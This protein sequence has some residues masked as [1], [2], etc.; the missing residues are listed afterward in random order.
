[1]EKCN[2]VIMKT[3]KN[4]GLALAIA[5]TLVMTAASCSSENDLVE[6]PNVEQPT[7]TQNSKVHVTVG[8]G[9]SDV[10]T[11]SV[12]DKSETDANGKPIRKLK[13]TAGDKLYVYAKY[14]SV[15]VRNEGY[16]PKFITGWLDILPASITDGTSASFTGDLTIYEWNKSENKYVETTHKFTNADPLVDCAEYCEQKGYQNEDPPEGVFAQLVHAGS[17]ANFYV[18]DDPEYMVFCSN[19]RYNYTNQDYLA[20]D[21]DSYMT[22]RLEV[23]ANTYDKD[24]HRFALSSPDNTAIFNCVI[25]GLPANTD[26]HVEIVVGEGAIDRGKVKTDGAGNAQFVAA[27]KEIDLGAERTYSIELT[28]INNSFDTYTISLGS[29]TLEKKIYNVS[30]HWNGTAF[31]KTIDLSTISHDMLVGSGMTLTGELS[32][33]YKI[34][35]AAGATVTLSGATIP[36]RDAT[37]KTTQW[38][39][40]TCLGDATIV[41]ADGTENYVKGYYCDFPGIQAG[42]AGTTLTIR[43]GSAGTGKLTAHTGM[44]NVGYAAGIGGGQDMAVGNIR[45]EGGDITATA[46]RGAA[47]IGSGH[48]YC[49][50]A[51]CGDITITGGTV[52]ATG[53]YDGAGIGSGGGFGGSGGSGGSGGKSGIIQKINYS[54][55]GNIS[56][57][58]GIIN[59]TGGTDSPCDIG[60]GGGNNA[61]CG[62]VS[63]AP[64]TINNLFACTFVV[65]Y[66]ASYT[67]SNNTVTAVP[68]YNVNSTLKVT[69]NGKNYTTTS[70][71]R[72]GETVTIDLSAVNGATVTV[73]TPNGTPY[74]SD[75]YTSTTPQPT[76]TFSCTIEN[77]TITGETNLGT[78]NLI[79][80][81]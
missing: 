47:G 29:R 12:V 22:S 73:S 40:I 53:G 38:A 70:T 3:F 27:Y 42:P 58:G 2:N 59:A 36:G 81:Q 79:R 50:T 57:S 66:Y 48:A 46:G 75:Q 74:D 18:E 23:M 28:N 30:R 32:G 68:V 71:Y 63:V 17:E 60:K 54:S 5:A 31:S 33:N 11:R 7:V 80:Q 35:I 64:G 26:Y 77:V 4:C 67:E 45:I 19:F 61:S 39:G 16:Y 34:S 10:M 44:S 24:N 1:M 76:A 20:P 37:D 25:S 15:Y 43:G 8:A 72:D 55:C 51:S 65:K 69:V 9:I 21:I 49:S 78:V 14:G 52:K 41:L 56:I 62:T 6:T 13:F